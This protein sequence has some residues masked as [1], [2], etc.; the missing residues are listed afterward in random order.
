[1]FQGKEMSKLILT[2]YKDDDGF[3]TK[4]SG[5]KDFSENWKEYGNTPDESLG[6][7]IISLYEQG[8]MSEPVLIE[9]INESGQD[10]G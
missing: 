9:I 8:Y 5:T 4:A 2:V 7:Q 1:M 3:R 10:W 6:A